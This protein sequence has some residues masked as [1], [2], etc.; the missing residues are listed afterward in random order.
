MP[1]WYQNLS[2][3]ALDVTSKVQAAMPDSETIPKAIPINKETLAKTTK[4]IQK[5]SLMSP[6]MVA[7][8]E[9]FKTEEEHRNAVKNSLANM[10][11]HFFVTKDEE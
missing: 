5:L 6:E 3:L 1:L 7:E 10:N 11:Q 9:K 8:Q 2:S 4:T